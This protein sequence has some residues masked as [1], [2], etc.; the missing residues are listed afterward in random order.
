MIP[1]EAVIQLLFIEC[2]FGFHRRPPDFAWLVD[3]WEVTD[4]R[5][6]TEVIAW[7]TSQ[8]E[9]NPFEVFLRWGDHHTSK[10][11]R[12]EPY[13]RYALIYGRPAIVETTAETVFFESE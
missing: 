6:V 8:A 12:L 11:G 9:G 5:Q 4:A 3:E 1:L 2:A 13:S 7:A 10:D